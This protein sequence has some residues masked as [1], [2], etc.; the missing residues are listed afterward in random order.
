MSRKIPVSILNSSSTTIDH[1]S[2][3]IELSAG[4]NSGKTSDNSAKARSRMNEES[5]HNALAKNGG[6]DCAFILGN[7]ISIPLGADSWGDL[8]HNLLDYLTPYYTEKPAEISSSLSES[9]YLISSFVKNFVSSSKEM[10]GVYDSALRYCVY[11][12]YNKLMHQKDTLLRAVALA[13]LKHRK[14]RIYTY[15]YDLFL[16]NQINHEDPNEG[17]KGYTG[18]KYKERETSEIIHLHGIVRDRESE[19]VDRV[20]LT[21]EEYFREYLNDDG[22]KGGWARQAQLELLKTKKVL[23]IG[24]SM[25]DLFQ[26]SLIEKVHKENNDWKCYALMCFKGL[27]QQDQ[28]KL[29][30][31]YYK[32]GI[33]IIFAESHSELPL[34]LNRI[35]DCTFSKGKDSA[36]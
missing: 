5:F 30:N 10:E 35:T 12:K 11:R 29:C 21:D 7:G 26:L 15:N 33:A 1:A 23:F 22:G 32:K 24:S 28:E 4:A 8:V 19:V 3:A 9:L 27:D 25:S 18:N 13:K 14:L 16:E 17:Y 31:F 2:T 6:E 34:I 36:I 20:I